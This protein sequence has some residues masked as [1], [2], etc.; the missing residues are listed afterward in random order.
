MLDTS[1]NE[2][3][4]L[5]ELQF[6]YESQGFQFV[7]TPQRGALPSFFEGY[8]P[9]ALARKGNE[10]VVIEVKSTGGPL[11]D[12]LGRIAERIQREPGYK[13]AFVIAQPEHGTV[14]SPSSDRHDVLKR[15]ASA[16]DLSNSGDL[17]GA[18]LL[19]WSALEAAVRRQLRE[20]TSAVRKALSASALVSAL[21]SFGLVEEEDKEKLDIAANFRN[22]VAHGETKANPPAETVA[23]IIGLANALTINI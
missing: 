5:D 19:A 13:F 2:S 14:I 6:K 16:Q 15:I 7:R 3:H 11:K 21:I 12:H 23:F 9:D 8:I 18:L 1:E 20:D 10:T 4:I 17:G 22:M